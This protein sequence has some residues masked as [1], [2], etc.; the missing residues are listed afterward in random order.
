MKKYIVIMLIMVFAS[1]CMAQKTIY[2]KPDANWWSGSIEKDVAWRWAKSTDG[3]VSAG[4]QLGTG[5]IFY[6]DSNVSNEGDGTTWGNAKDTLDEAIALCTAARGDLILIAQGHQEVEASAASIFDIDVAGVTVIGV[7]NS[8]RSGSVA[9]GVATGSLMPVFI[10]DH[11]SA[12]ATISAPNCRVSGLKFESDVADNAIGL[13]VTGSGDGVVIDNCMF[14]DGAQAEEMVI[15]INVVTAA[16]D[17]QI[18]N[19]TFSTVAGGGCANA[20]VIAGVSSNTIISGN[21]AYGTYSAGTV[22]ASASANVNFT[23]SGNT[24]CNVGA[25][26]LALNASTTGVITGNFLGGTTSTAATMTGDDAC[27]L[28]ENY[29]TGS[30]ILSGI[31]DPGNV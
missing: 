22:L 17:C 9:A 11:A 24:F 5:E 16:N 1:M 29:V 25:L 10:L 15:G 2:S 8:G 14:R 6:V 19:N 3:L 26:A 18:L 31:L 13:T 21:V 30:L 23:I 7:S 12:T 4:L 28:F 27:F 20:I